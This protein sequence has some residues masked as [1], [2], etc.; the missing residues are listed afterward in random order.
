MALPAFAAAGQPRRHRQARAS[1][2]AVTTLSIASN[3]AK[4]LGGGTEVRLLSEKDREGSDILGR[5][6]PFAVAERL[7]RAWRQGGLNR[8]WDELVDELPPGL[9]GSPMAHVFC[10]ILGESTASVPL[11]SV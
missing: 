9:T 5:L 8:P 11:E 3:K 4:T 6:E 7:L 1:C 2:T 10:T